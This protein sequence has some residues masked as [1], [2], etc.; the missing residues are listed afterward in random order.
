MH[1]N[2]SFTHTQTCTCTHTHTQSLTF[3]L[4]PSLATNASSFFE[5]SIT[6]LHTYTHTHTHSLTFQLWPSL[7]TN[8]SSFFE[9][10]ITHLNT[11]THTNT[12]TH[13]PSS[14]GPASPPM[15]QASSSPL[16]ST[17]CS[18]ASSLACAVRP[19]ATP[20]DT[21]WQSCPCP[22]PKQ[23]PPTARGLNMQVWVPLQ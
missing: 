7:A 6:H 2:Y 21:A 12:H 9:S 15:P 17:L 8:A 11:H 14:C 5:S 22:D 1:T 10:S 20:S 19:S 23:P 18:C 3:Q 13:S 4:W 16:G